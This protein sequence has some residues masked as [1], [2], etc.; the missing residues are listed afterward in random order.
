MALRQTGKQRSV[1][2]PLDYFQKPDR[3]TRGKVWLSGVAVALCVLWILGIGWNPRDWSSAG[4]RSR[5]LASHGTLARVHATWDNACEACHMPFAPI[6]GSSWAAKLVGNAQASDDRCRTCHA[7]PVHHAS[8]SAGDVPSCARCHQDHQGREHSLVAVANHECTACHAALSLHRQAGAGSGIT[9]SVTAFDGDLAHHPEAAIFRAGTAKDPGSIKFNH[10]LHLTKGLTLVKGG[11]PLKTVNDLAE[12]D[13]DSYRT[14]GLRDTDGIQLR[15]DSCHRLEASSAGSSGVVNGASSN[16]AIRSGGAYMLPIRYNAQCRACHQLDYDPKLPPVPH[17]K[18]PAELRQLLRQAYSGLYLEHH[19]DTKATRELKSPLPGR[20]ESA[21]TR[22]AREW[23]DERV[24]TAERV[25]YGAKKC[26]ECHEISE[27]SDNLRVSGEIP[28]VWMPRAVFD[29]SAHRA[30]NCRECHARAYSDAPKASQ[31]SSDVMIPGIATCQR[32]HTERRDDRR[33][34]SG[35]ASTRCTEC[36]RYH[37]GD[38][39]FEGRGAAARDAVKPSSLREFL[40]GA[41]G[42]PSS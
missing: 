3:L 36:H 31:A 16:R 38:R 8:A 40:R 39:P 15:C 20:Q 29:H 13:R 34:P 33:E 21:E 6:D 25:L 22:V 28:S 5:A 9:E 37:N 23:V 18:Q 19:P 30:V 10:A 7:G 27:S 14:R 24:A 17:G 26:G 4:M 11:V 2:I 12:S 41:P 32:C 1:R 42:A 35:G